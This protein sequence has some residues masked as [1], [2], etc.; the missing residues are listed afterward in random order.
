MPEEENGVQTSTEIELLPNLKEKLEETIF[1]DRRVIQ[2]HGRNLIVCTREEGKEIEADFIVLNQ[3]NT[4]TDAIHAK[5]NLSYPEDLKLLG[6]LNLSKKGIPKTWVLIESSVSSPRFEEGIPE[7]VGVIKFSVDQNRV[8]NFRKVSEAEYVNPPYF[9]RTKQVIKEL[10]ETEDID[11]KRY[12]LVLSSQHNWDI[13]K[14]RKQYGMPKLL[15]NGR[16]DPMT[17]KF[18]KTPIG[19]VIM[20]HVKR[21]GIVGCYIKT[22]DMFESHEDVGWKDNRGR[23]WLC[24]MRFW[25]FPIVTD[26][27][28]KPI[29]WNEIRSKM[30]RFKTGHPQGRIELTKNDYETVLSTLLNKNKNELRVTWH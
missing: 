11:I 28:P 15:S 26:E 17:Q 10:I 6:K 24:E 27:F 19:S 14:R 18:E 23:P 21:K 7:R 1:R 4:P 3:D 8:S 29:Q 9:M 25:M 22:S 30:S 2:T 20:I 12:W 13:C 5:L 16:P